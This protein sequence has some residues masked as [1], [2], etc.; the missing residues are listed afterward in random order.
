MIATE[1][2]YCV[3]M[4]S[5]EAEKFSNWLFGQLREKS[6]SQSQLAIRAGISRGTLSNILTGNRRAGEDTLRAIAKALKLPP[7]L[8]F[9]KAGLLPPKPATE[10][11]VE[12]LTHLLMLLPPEERQ[13]IYDLIRVKLDRQAQKPPS[14][15]PKPAR[16]H[17]KEG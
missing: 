2:A 7:E 6:W 11:E 8:V 17:L 16:T 13:D 1:S 5:V 3:K 15:M 14:R 12:V 9:R 10:S 4:F